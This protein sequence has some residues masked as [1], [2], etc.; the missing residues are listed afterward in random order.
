MTSIL[1]QPKIKNIHFIGIG[2]IGMSGLAEILWK[3]GYQLSGSDIASNRVIEH[4]RS[5]G[6][7][8]FLNHDAQNIKNADAAV[9][10]SAI[11]LENPEYTTAK[12]MGM[13]V[14]QRGQLLADIMLDYE[15]IAIAGTHGKTTTTA[16]IVHLLLTGKL[17]PS[18][19]IGGI[20][21]NSDSPANL[22]KGPYFVAES[23][24]S[25]ASFLLLRPKILIVTNIDADHLSTY[26]GS[27]SRLKQS[28]VKFI[29]SIP[30]DGLA[31]L[32][33]D[34]PGVAEIIPQLSCR[35]VTY[36][37]ENSA[38]IQGKNYQSKKLQ[39]VFDVRRVQ[40]NCDLSVKLNLPGFHN[41]S[42]TLA[43]IALAK[44]LKISDEILLSALATF[45]GV[46]RRFH[47]HGE[48]AVKNGTALLFD[49]YGHHPNEIKMTLRAAKQ[50]WPDQR[51]VLVFQPHRYTRTRDLMADF[52]E[53][54]R[55]A[56]LLIMLSVYSAGEAPI[57]GA[58]AQTLCQRIL[59][60]GKIN[61]IF[62]PELEEL[63]VVLKDVLE[64]GDIVLFQG[65]GSI[66][67]MANKICQDKNFKIVE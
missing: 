18:Y 29:Q 12:A 8:I 66:G 1:K 7:N 30:S 55:E 38:D 56:D 26:Q 36:G 39:S 37:F 6:I 31:I 4:L 20:L 46:G 19:A 11:S 53:V 63:P 65:A 13:P 23:D 34:D 60:K 57:A 59:E 43:V 15:G 64:S 49:D 3:K 16:I 48:I 33:K 32:N 51:L 44:E 45:P 2:G 35:Y 40:E 10:T 24:E 41:A 42:N 61:P 67:P 17:D 58:D 54:L 25:D 52:A 50:A 47:S 28:F 22:G 5:L 21:K 27:F 9:Y 62:V 14:I